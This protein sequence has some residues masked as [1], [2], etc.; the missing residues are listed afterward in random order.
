MTVA[1]ANELFTGVP[2]RRFRTVTLPV[3]GATVRIQSLTEREF[4]GYQAA[5]FNNKGQIRPTG[6]RDATRRLIALCL[7]DDDGNRVCG[8]E[9]V[10]QLAE[11][12]SADTQ[13]LYGQCAEHCGINSD[14]IED[15]V[16]NSK[17]IPD[18]MIA[19]D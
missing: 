3:M 9:Q 7:V 11:W 15:L 12:D 18:D 10:S 1:T 5:S 14:D 17:E 4:S 13:F 8:S 19:T 6:M 2:K 16:K